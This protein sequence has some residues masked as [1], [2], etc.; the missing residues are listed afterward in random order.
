[1]KQNYIK[2]W[3]EIVTIATTPMMAVSN[4]NERKA[5]VSEEEVTTGYVDSR[6]YD[7]W[8]DEEDEY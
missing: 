3:T 1:M 2:P 7:I 8:T 6:S 4:P 5:V